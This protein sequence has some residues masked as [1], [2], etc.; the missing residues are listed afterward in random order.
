[1]ARP[2]SDESPDIVSAKL[3]DRELY[4]ASGK[5]VKVTD[6]QLIVELKDGRTISAPLKWYP[7]LVDG[8]PDERRNVRISANGL[9]WPDLDED[10]SIRGMLLGRRDG[11]NPAVLRFWRNARRKGQDAT[12]EAF[13]K[14][15]RKRVMS[16]R[17]TKT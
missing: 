7:R 13:M 1:M 6:E 10:I 17:R 4:R 9:H 8:T 12:F 3:A 11:T 15:K 5:H 2:K 16:T 14:A